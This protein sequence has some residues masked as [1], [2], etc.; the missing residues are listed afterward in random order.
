MKTVE[1]YEVESL[2]ECAKILISD[3]DWLIRAYE[4]EFYHKNWERNVA[5]AVADVK[6]SQRE[7]NKKLRDYKKVASI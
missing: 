6:A 7:F 2:V 3:L 1:E 5:H 4:G